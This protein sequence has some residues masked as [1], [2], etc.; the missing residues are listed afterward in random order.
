MVV[1]L[2]NTVLR[3]YFI[4]LLVLIIVTLWITLIKTAWAAPRAL[5]VA[6]TT[7]KTCSVIAITLLSAFIRILIIDTFCQAVL[8]FDLTF[9]FANFCI[10]QRVTTD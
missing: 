3:A 6:W 1:A 2:Y 7:V 9:V 5:V 4:V 8:K 10:V